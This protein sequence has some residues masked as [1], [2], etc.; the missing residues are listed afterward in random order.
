MEGV[1]IDIF[2]K[3]WKHFLKRKV[4][5]FLLVLIPPILSTTNHLLGIDGA[6]L[7]NLTSEFVGIAVTVF[8]VDFFV[9]QDRQRDR[10]QLAE[11]SY[12]VLRRLVV[13]LQKNLRRA[14]DFDSL[15]CLTHKTQIVKKL[16]QDDVLNQRRIVYRVPGRKEIERLENGIFLLDA[17]EGAKKELQLT[18]TTFHFFWHSELFKEVVNLDSLLDHEMFERYWYALAEPKDLAPVIH[19]M[20]HSCSKILELINKED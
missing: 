10:K 2:K 7:S 19:R 8:L 20:G 4:I 9:D 16:D 17:L 1:A 18:M 11:A 14:L 6:I 12:V 13:R 3:L 5:L 15:D